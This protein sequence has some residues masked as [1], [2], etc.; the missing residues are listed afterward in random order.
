MKKEN[1]RI[2]IAEQDTIDMHE[3]II[4]EILECIEFEGALV[5]DL[6]TFSDFSFMDDELDEKIIN[7]IQNQFNIKIRMNDNIAETALKIYHNRKTSKT[8]H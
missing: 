6:S 4:D 2:V 8:I 5:T 3:D 7:S 1:Y